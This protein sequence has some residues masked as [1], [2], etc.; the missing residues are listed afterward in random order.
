MKNLFSVNS[1]HV[2][3]TERSANDAVFSYLKASIVAWFEFLFVKKQKLHLHSS[4]HFK[5]MFWGEI[6]SSC[7]TLFAA[8]FIFVVVKKKVAFTPFSNLNTCNEYPEKKSF[9][10]FGYK[11]ELW[12]LL[13]FF[14]LWLFINENNSN[15]VAN[16]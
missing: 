12:K 7:W 15:N 2:Q 4:Q 6:F 10:I 8:W 13:S 11:W 16:Y 9:F 5:H 14:D 3:N 1:T